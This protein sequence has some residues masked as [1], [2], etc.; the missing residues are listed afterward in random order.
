MTFDKCI[1]V[2]LYQ[3]QFSGCDIVLQSHKYH[4]WEE[5]SNEYV[6]SLYSFLQLQVNLQFSQN[7]RNTHTHTHA[8]RSHYTLA[9]MTKIKK[10]DNVKC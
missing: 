7:K 3:H 4:H 1:N 9:K 5:M 8:M 10:T 2:K 6:G